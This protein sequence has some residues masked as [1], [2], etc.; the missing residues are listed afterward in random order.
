MDVNELQ[1][2]LEQRLLTLGGGEETPVSLDHYIV[3][4]FSAGEDSAMA[5]LCSRVTG[6]DPGTVAFAT[7]ASYLQQL[8]MDVVVMGPGSID[9]A[10]QPDEYLELAQIPRSIDLIRQLIVESCLA[11][12]T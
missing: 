9:Q 10:H 1:A 4:P 11:P 3:P 8:G 12:A 5:A 2:L 7:E 6:E